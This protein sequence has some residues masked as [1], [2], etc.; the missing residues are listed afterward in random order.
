MFIHY[1]NSN[2]LN[3][4]QLLYLILS[5]LL[6]LYGIITKFIYVSLIKGLSCNIFVDTSIVFI[7]LVLT[8]VFVSFEVV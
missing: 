1:Q 2:A 5:C 4:Y 8:I 6:K 7:S 3:L